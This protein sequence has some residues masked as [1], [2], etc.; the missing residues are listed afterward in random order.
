MRLCYLFAI[1]YPLLRLS[2]PGL[3]ADRAACPRWH[4]PGM[5]ASAIEAIGMKAA[6]IRT[7]T[8]ESGTH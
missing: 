5:R 4:E 6:L 3:A 1:V 7:N 8:E 2:F